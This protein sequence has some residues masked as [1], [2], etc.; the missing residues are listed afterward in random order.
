MA[1]GCFKEITKLG[2]TPDI[3][4][5]NGLIGT[6]CTA[7]KYDSAKK[8]KTM[9]EDN[10]IEP[11]SVTYEA[12]LVAMS[13]EKLVLDVEKYFL[14]MRKRGLQSG[15][16]VWRYVIESYVRSGQMD[17]SFILVD[18]MILENVAIKGPLKN[19]LLIHCKRKNKLGWYKERFGEIPD[20]EPSIPL[21]GKRR[22][23]QYKKYEKVFED[24][25]LDWNLD[26]DV[27]PIVAQA[28]EKREG[29]ESMYKSRLQALEEKFLKQPLR[30]EHKDAMIEGQRSMA[31]KRR[32][33]K[34]APDYVPEKPFK[35]KVV[36]KKEDQNPRPRKPRRKTTLKD[37]RKPRSQ[38]TFKNK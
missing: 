27:I 36:K 22:E 13:K 30:P 20:T 24:K 14:E 34:I 26:G 8:I 2:L 28:K 4:S 9:M 37:T 1:W 25:R 10:G 18:Q 31:D 11:N 7:K 16:N 29:E 17:K 33:A 23:S 12:L 5:W 6:L 35:K 19:I 15:P 38:F 3:D 21:F 32:K